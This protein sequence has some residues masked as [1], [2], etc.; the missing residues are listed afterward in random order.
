MCSFFLLC[1][2][3]TGCSC[4]IASRGRRKPTFSVPGTTVVLSVFAC[5]DAPSTESFTLSCHFLNRL[6]GIVLFFLFQIDPV[7]GVWWNGR[8]VGL[9]TQRAKREPALPPHRFHT[10][11]YFPGCGAA[12][13]EGFNRQ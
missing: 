9:L 6:G 13:A 1:P 4:R 2:G 10:D 7:S 8:T 11:G 5:R 12:A 3:K